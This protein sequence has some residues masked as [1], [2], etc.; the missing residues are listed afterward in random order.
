MK[1]EKII[2]FLNNLSSP[3]ERREV[4]SW[5]N[6]PGSEEEVFE[7]FQ[8][9]WEKGSFDRIDEEKAKLILAKIHRAT[10]KGNNG[11]LRNTNLG[12]KFAKWGRIAASYFLLG[13]SI[14]FLR[15]GFLFEKPILPSEAHVANLIERK[16][17]AGEKLSILL[18]DKSSVILNSLSTIKFYSD[19]GTVSREL[20]IE[21]EA[22]FEVAENREIPFLVTVGGITTKAIG[23]A[24]NVFSRG[25][26]VKISLTEG[27]VRVLS[28]VASMD[29][30]PGEM[31]TIQGEKRRDL[32][33]GKFD[34][35]HSFRWKDGEISFRSKKFGDILKTL[36]DWYGVEIVIQGDLN[37]NRKITGIFKNDNLRDVLTGLGYFMN[38]DFKLID[39]HVTLK[40][41][42][43]ME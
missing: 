28:S 16:T 25:D 35:N 1:E 23:T 37:S 6:E 8:T 38:F 22:F 18:P 19:F 10:G 27:K 15:E 17:R 36:E 9:R 13:F 40:S 33:K 31:A 24:F 41:K 43:P 3:K 42:S 2:R 29:L 14:Y 26:V 30:M 7:F 4:V 34:K 12:H 11:I 21:G 32:V 20:E 39:N 5:L